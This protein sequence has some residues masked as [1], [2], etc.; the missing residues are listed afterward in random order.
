MVYEKEVVLNIRHRIELCEQQRL[1]DDN[2]VDEDYTPLEATFASSRIQLGSRQR[3][4]K[5]P[6]YEKVLE[7]ML[8]FRNFGNSLAGFLRVH[9]S[10][11]VRG[12]DFDGDGFEGHQYC[13]YW[14]K[15]ISFSSCSSSQLTG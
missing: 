3:G 7:E 14:Y 12:P 10:V 2:V 9:T 15:V 1:F 11:D 13:I 8:G 5:I 6:S 4:L